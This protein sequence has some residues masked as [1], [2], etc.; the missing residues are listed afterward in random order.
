MPNDI[1]L[2]G[3]ALGLYPVKNAD[4]VLVCVENQRVV[5]CSVINWNLRNGALG[6]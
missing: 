3:T 1:A 2:A 6:K 5:G 4:E